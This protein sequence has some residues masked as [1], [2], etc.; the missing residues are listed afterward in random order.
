MKTRVIPIALSI[1]VLAAAACAQEEAAPEMAKPESLEDRASYAIGLN[2]GRQMTDQ[3]VPINLDLL[4]QGI[5]DGM[6]DGETLLTNDEIQAAMQEFQ[7]MMMQKAQENQA[8]LAEEGKTA[9]DEFLASN[10]DK[11]GVMTTESGL[12]Y[13]VLTEGDG[14]KPTSS[15]TVTV[16]YTG[17]LLDGTEFDSS[18]KRGQ[19]AT[20]PVTGV[21]AGWTEALQMM[22]VGSKWKLYIPP[23]LAYGA[24]GQGPIPPNSLL[25]FEVELIGIADQSGEGEGGGGR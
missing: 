21:I 2:M 19:P 7:Q 18:H 1:L 10:K 11:E 5:K 23:D 20:F 25:T 14:P 3:E 16:H 4:M 8:A 24:R 9:A 6:G 12:Q 17:T 22:P 13:E 15:D